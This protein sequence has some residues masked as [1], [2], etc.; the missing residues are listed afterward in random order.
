M[1]RLFVLRL[2]AGLIGGVIAYK[3][4]R[5]TLLWA[6]LSA[7]FPPLIVV[8][9]L[10]PPLL[11]PG[12]TRQCPYCARIVYRNDTKCRYC[13]RELPIELVRCGACGSYVPDKE[14]CANCHK[15]LRE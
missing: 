11:A 2:I 8:V 15:K 1:Y 14:Y 4:G 13:G 6:L 5:G 9:L 3:K 10:L 7:L 12:R